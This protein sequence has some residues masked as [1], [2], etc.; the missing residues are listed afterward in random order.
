M[1]SLQDTENNTPLTGISTKG[2]SR[3]ALSMAKVCSFGQMDQFTKE[4]GG[5]ER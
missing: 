2:N 1:T 4:T 5:R 3:M